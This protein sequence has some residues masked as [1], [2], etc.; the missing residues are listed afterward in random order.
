VKDQ[1]ISAKHK[2]V[3][4]SY[5]RAT[6]PALNSARGILQF[7]TGTLKLVSQFNYF[8]AAAIYN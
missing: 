6:V 3:A 2:E 7:Q 8:K 1:V 5:C 4:G